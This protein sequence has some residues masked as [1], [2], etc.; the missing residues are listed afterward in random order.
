MPYE[1]NYHTRKL[2]VPVTDDEKNE[3]GIDAAK[4]RV[5]MAE[6]KAKLDAYSK[7]TREFLKEQEEE[8]LELEQVAAT[9]TKPEKVECVDMWFDSLQVQTIRRDTCEVI[10]EMRP[11]KP[12]E[13]AQMKRMQQTAMP[14]EPVIAEIEAEPAD[15]VDTTTGEVKSKRGR[16]AKVKLEEVEPVH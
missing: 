3:A 10:E 11:M 5:R 6:E 2:P 12:D 14:F 7:A 4:I 15:D 8:A 1:K 9:G 16:K 13:V